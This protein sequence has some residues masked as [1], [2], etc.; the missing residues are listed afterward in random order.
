MMSACGCEMWNSFARNFRDARTPDL[1]SLSVQGSIV[2]TERFISEFVDD[3]I[4]SELQGRYR[5]D[6]CTF[7]S[8]MLA[9]KIEIKF[10]LHES[11]LFSTDLLTNI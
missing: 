6:C 10:W 5:R 11:D 3:F 2:F 9:A 4:K 1:K 8:F 7:F